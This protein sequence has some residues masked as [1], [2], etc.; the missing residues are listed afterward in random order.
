MKK[1]I[2]IILLIGLFALFELIQIA[3]SAPKAKLKARGSLVCIPANDPRIESQPCWTDPNIEG[4]LIRDSWSDVEPEPNQF[5]WAFL[6]EGVKLGLEHGKAI[7][8]SVEC[9][10]KSPAWINSAVLQ[11]QN[12]KGTQPYPWD[13]THLAAQQAL[14]A[15]FGARYDSNPVVASVTIW[16]G[17]WNVECM[18]ASTPAL[19]S[20]LD[21]LGG[22][23]LW[24]KAAEQMI[25][26]YRDAFPT[27]ELYLA[28]GE[29]YLD[30]RAT[31][32]S[33]AQ[34]AMNLGIGLQS[35]GL[36]GDFPHPGSTFFPHT[37]VPLSAVK[38]A[39][40]QLLA[41][42]AYTARMASHIPNT[43]AGII[44]NGKAHAG[45]WIEFYPRDP[46]LDE[47]AL[48]AYNRSFN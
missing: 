12:A 7:Q 16:C 30:N 27:T 20:E 3:R 47:A 36:S 4:V 34:Y 11:W 38:L 25:T 5:N 23:R 13:P 28:T 6:D 22:P 32:T 40:Y 48:A 21:S 18:F 35:N 9:G 19:K 17:G 37:N 42:V 43:V 15:T 26:W 41:P 10:G 39:G 29:P 2:P 31:M 33:L 44:A 24:V 14:I 1:L 45:L 8:L 46:Q